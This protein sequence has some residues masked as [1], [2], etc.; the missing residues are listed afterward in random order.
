VEPEQDERQPVD[1]QHLQVPELRR[2]VRRERPGEPGQEGGIMPADEEP[3]EQIGRER[4]QRPAEIEA[5]VVGREGAAGQPEQRCR[6]HADA[7]QVLREC[8]DVAARMEV[9]R[10]PPRRRERHRRRVPPQDRRVQDGIVRIVGDAG[11][12]ALQ[13]RVRVDR[14]DQEV[15]ARDRSDASGTPASCARTLSDG[16]HRGGP[17]P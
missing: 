7:D 8:R 10:T 1:R 6:Q 15:R 16:S 17:S 13:Y 3:H 14:G 9:R 4:R 11:E 5:D 12:A 2:P